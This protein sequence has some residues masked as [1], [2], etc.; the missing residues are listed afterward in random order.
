MAVSPITDIS[1]SVTALLC[2]LPCHAVA[3]LVLPAA[4]L[5]FSSPL[6]TDV[7]RSTISLS[8]REKMETSVNPATVLDT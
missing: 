6:S 3:S 8:T 1:A 5:S 4:F 7:S 2:F